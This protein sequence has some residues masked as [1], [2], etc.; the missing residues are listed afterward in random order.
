MKT[1]IKVGK[2]AHTIDETDIILDNGACYQI[3][4]R[5]REGKYYLHYDLSNIF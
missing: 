5:N 2:K 1:R 3:L 4:S